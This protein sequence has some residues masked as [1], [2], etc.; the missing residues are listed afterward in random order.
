MRLYLLLLSQLR[1]KVSI[2][3]FEGDRTKAKFPLS[4]F[5]TRRNVYW[6]FTREMKEVQVR[7]ICNFC[8]WH[9]IQLDCLG[10]N[11]TSWSTVG[12]IPT[13][14]NTLS[15]PC[16]ISIHIRIYV[17][18]ISFIKCLYNN[19]HH[20]PSFNLQTNIHFHYIALHPNER[21]P[22]KFQKHSVRSLY[23]ISCCLNTHH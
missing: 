12:R 22:S 14:Y 11:T 15:R 1:L 23:V 16:S 7:G 8:F 6:N 4:L 17:P 5:S 21:R 9:S 18:Y 19:Y 2:Q 10:K 3:Y 13:W 20:L